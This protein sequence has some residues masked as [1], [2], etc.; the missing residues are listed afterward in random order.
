[1]KELNKNIIALCVAL[2]TLFYI[3]SCN[4]YVRTG[5]Y[6]TKEHDY[7]I[8]LNDDST[9]MYDYGFHLGEY[10]SSGLWTQKGKRIFLTSNIQD[11]M[12][13]PV[14]LSAIEDDNSDSTFIVFKG[15]NLLYYDWFCLADTDTIHL[16][17]DTL[18]A[19]F[20]CPFQMF[21]CAKPISRP[22]LYSQSFMGNNPAFYAAPR[23]LL[24]KSEPIIIKQ[25]TSH[26]IS[27]DSVFG[28]SP[29]YYIP[30]KKELFKLSKSGIRDMQMG[31]LLTFMGQGW[32]GTGMEQGM[33]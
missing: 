3:T 6:S 22:S 9:Y 27:V 31:F 8:V 15:I 1:M 33:K 30:F 24:V 21:L 25:K 28:E 2:S 18:Y 12:N 5:L 14:A 32:D 4:R 11:V 16:V 23:D 17:N 19:E 7:K 13:F 26:K 10:V 29:L 20:R